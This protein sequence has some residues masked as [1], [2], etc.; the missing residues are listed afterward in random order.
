MSQRQRLELRASAV[1]SAQGSRPAQEDHG[2]VNRD[3][4]IFVVSDGFGGLLPVPPPRRLRARR[5]RRS[6]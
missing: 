3:K 1:F 4:R 2:L 5:F 6:C